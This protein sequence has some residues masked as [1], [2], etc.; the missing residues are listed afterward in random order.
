MSDHY[1]WLPDLELFGIHNGD[2]EK[3]LN[4]LYHIFE[5]D[6]IRSKPVFRGRR[7]GLKRFPLSKGKEVTFWHMTSEGSDEEDRI[8]D[9]RRCERIRWPRPSIDNCD[10][11]GIRIWTEPRGNESRIHIYLEEE[12]YLVVLAD[13]TDYILPWTAYYVQR[14]H[15]Q[16]KL[17][18]KHEAFVASQAQ[19]G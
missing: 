14:T 15:Q 1:A 5:N 16:Q 9:L 17:I 2:W 8:P 13:R 6:F 10:T 11:A 3:Y 12:A 18:K 4:V 7:L 19:K